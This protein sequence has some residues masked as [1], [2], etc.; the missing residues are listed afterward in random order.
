[1]MRFITVLYLSVLFC[2]Q[3]WSQNNINFLIDR[4]INSNDIWTQS[5][6]IE[7]HPFLFDKWKIAT[8][9]TTKGTY[10]DILIKL[11]LVQD[12]IYFQGDGGYTMILSKDHVLSFVMREK[13]DTALTFIHVPLNGYFQILEDGERSLLLKKVK[14]LVSADRAETVSNVSSKITKE[15]RE[16]S[17]YYLRQEGI[18][19]SIESNKS[20]RRMFQNDSGAISFINKNKVKVNN[21]KALISLVKFLN[22]RV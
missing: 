19:F 20:L 12:E 17:F 8:I 21:E 4:K 1:M 2:S 9:E 6:L 13:D 22:E 18:M 14:E 5:D 15:H 16:K 7:G 10:N 3:G 11:N